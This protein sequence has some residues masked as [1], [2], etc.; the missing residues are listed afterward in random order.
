MPQ[1]CAGG[2]G[3]CGWWW[4]VDADEDHIGAT[5]VVLASELRQGPHDGV[6]L[7][8]DSQVPAGFERFLRLIAEVSSVD[9]QDRGHA[10][11]RWKQYA[12]RGYA[13]TRHDLALKGG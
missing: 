5:R 4:C 1:F 8:L 9:E 6:R 2:A 11:S 7:N 12:S 13:I 10:R 3:S